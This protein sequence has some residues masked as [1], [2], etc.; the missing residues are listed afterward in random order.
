MPL[1]PLIELLY[2]NFVEVVRYK[3][4]KSS[5]NGQI[6]SLIVNA[7]GAPVFKSSKLSVWPLMCHVVELPVPLIKV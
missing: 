4:I 7:D 2:I 5:V 3:V 6:V 1:I